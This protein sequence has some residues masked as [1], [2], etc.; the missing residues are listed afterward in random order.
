M[1]Q[2]INSL[3]SH[4]R[5][6]KAEVNRYKKKVRD[7]ETDIDRQKHMNDKKQSREEEVLKHLNGLENDILATGLKEI[8][9]LQASSIPKITLILLRDLKPA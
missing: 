1:R 6:L 9:H 3:Q 8:V 5:Q 2:L 7:Y 4:N